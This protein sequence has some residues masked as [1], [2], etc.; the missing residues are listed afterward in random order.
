VNEGGIKSVKRVLL[1]LLTNIAVIVVLS[2]VL[3]LLGVDRI[4]GESGVGLNYWNLLIFASVF[5]FGGAF[6]SLVISKWMAKR[7][8]GALLIVDS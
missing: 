2:V 6:I 7:L 8:T 1:F 5:G 4:L 3:R